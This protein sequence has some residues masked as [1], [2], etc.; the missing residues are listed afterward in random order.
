M[1]LGSACVAVVGCARPEA[2][3]GGPEDRFPPYVV[4]T[5]PDTFAVV[6]EG[7]REFEFKFSE[8]ISERAA[9][10]AMRDA[11]L[12][13]PEVGALR[14]RHRRDAISVEAQ[15]GL[16]PNRVYRVTVLPVVSDMFGNTLRDPFDLLVST[17]AEFVP[18]V[19]AGVVENRVDGTAAAGVRVEAVFGQ[20]GDAPP[21][22]SYADA[23]GFYS[24]RFVPAG[25]FEL[26]AWQDRDRD[27]EPG[28]SEP[29]ASRTGGA[30]AAADTAYDVLSLVEPDTTAAQLVGAT[31][32]DSVTI[33]FEFD[34]YLDPHEPG[35][36]IEGVLF[37][38][39]EDGV[40]VFPLFHDHEHAAWKAEQADSAGQAAP[41]DA[42][43]PV[44]G[45]SGLILP[46]QTLTG[47]LP[48]PLEANRA[49][50][51][52]LTGVFNLAGLEARGVKIVVAREAAQS[53]S[54][55]AGAEEA[56]SDTT[57]SRPDTTRTPPDTMVA[58]RASSSA[59]RATRMLL[60][61]L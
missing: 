6:Q 51:A 8:R 37:P 21:H 27:G 49:Y 15:R 40:I 13:S 58:P 36:A 23:D 30:L 61:L 5:V 41:A 59:M 29:F 22:W 14:V 3:P 4:A 10:G 26:R 7:F 42:P 32:S 55:T 25:P 31:V 45:L 43:E 50:E 46:S 24:L 47:T 12:V 17:G 9:G 11:V 20:D 52:V 38:D 44:V 2:P 16:L 48:E 56:A 35:A 19:V 1:L 18:N 53:D 33:T 60:R 39:G 57:R 28:P 54:A 34:D